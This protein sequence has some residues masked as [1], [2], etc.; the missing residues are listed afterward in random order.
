MAQA[1]MLL[2]GSSQ[3]PAHSISKSSSSRSHGARSAAEL[4]ESINKL[5]ILQENH[6]QQYRQEIQTVQQQQAVELAAIT[7][8]LKNSQEMYEKLSLEREVLIQRVRQLESTQPAIGPRPSALPL[9]L[10]SS[11]AA[12]FVQTVLGI[13]YEPLGLPQPQERAR[14]VRLSAAHKDKAFA[15]KD[16]SSTEKE[17]RRSSKR[18]KPVNVKIAPVPLNAGT[19]DS[20]VPLVAKS[21]TR[22]RLK[23]IANPKGL[24]DDEVSVDFE[25]A[26]STFDG[27]SAGRVGVKRPRSPTSS[28]QGPAKAPKKAKTTSTAARNKIN[29]PPIPRGSDG[30]PLLPMQIGMFTLKNMGR[31]LSPDD[32]ATQKT[33]YP[34][35]Y[36][37]ERRWFSTI[38]P[39][40]LVNY[41]C[42]IE[43]GKDPQ[44]PKF[45]VVP[46]DA[47]A[48]EGH[49][50]TAA[51]W[52]I[53]KE[54]LRVRNQPEQAVMNGDE[55]FG[56]YD[57]VIK[58]LLQELP[59]ASNV[60]EYVWRT[61]I[62][63][64]P[65][66]KRR[67]TANAVYHIESGTRQGEPWQES[68]D[69][70]DTSLA[71][72]ADNMT[73]SPISPNGNSALSATAA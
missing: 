19:D 59:G 54:G 48:H 44:H 51:W 56:L 35:G 3:P 65:S 45:V 28:A 13:H 26:D 22:I 61:F 34:I 17:S 2:P 25:V 30:A 43:A 60:G 49:T 1:T 38:D 50:A 33:L 39:K 16:D 70:N 47:P 62:E 15:L 27:A 10:P 64:V 32:L 73:A 42:T 53:Y 4:I 11:R 29:I 31:I 37:C 6:E 69:A 66:N 63:A 7:S 55:M 41:V 58:A 57:N 67:N 68:G 5:R 18:Q 72:I 71:S 12:S 20:G 52:E 46:E 8:E 14:P 21:G 40:A 36:H 24:Q 9:G 23:P